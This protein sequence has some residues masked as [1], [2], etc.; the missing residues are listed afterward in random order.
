MLL[1]NK[2]WQH[3]REVLKN[4]YNH[5]GNHKYINAQNFHH[6]I[7]KK[8][9]TS[10]T[11]GLYWPKLQSRY[12]PETQA[13]NYKGVM[14]FL[15]QYVHKH[16]QLPKQTDTQRDRTAGKVAYPTQIKARMK[17]QRD[18]AAATWGT[19]SPEWSDK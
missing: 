1:N 12:T 13:H 7:E 19:L 15:H 2:K 10:T 11:V 16:T 8:T 4:K 6:T 14:L 9:A 18:K 17:G 5:I 3:A